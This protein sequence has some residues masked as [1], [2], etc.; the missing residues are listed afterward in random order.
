MNVNMNLNLTGKFMKMLYKIPAVLMTAEFEDGR[1][2]TKR[3]LP[4]VLKNDTIISSLLL[5]DNDFAQ[6]MNGDMNTGKVK[7][8]QFT[9]DGIK[10]YSDEINY[11]Y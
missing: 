10:Y 9:G 1:V 11:F 7:S 2:I 4:E 6:F 5:D 3:V 8:I